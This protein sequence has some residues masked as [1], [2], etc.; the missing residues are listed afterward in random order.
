VEEKWEAEAQSVAV[1]VVEERIAVVAGA[2]L[3]VVLG[4]VEDSSFAECLRAEAHVAVA[5]ALRKSGLYK[6]WVAFMYYLD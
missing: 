2:E 1:A 5:V 3:C 6:R 4:Q